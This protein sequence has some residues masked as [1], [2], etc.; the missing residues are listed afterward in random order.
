MPKQGNFIFAG[1]SQSLYRSRA[2]SYFYGTEYDIW[3]DFGPVGSTEKKVGLIMSNFLG[4][5]FQVFM[6]KKNKIVFLKY[7]SAIT[8]KLHNIKM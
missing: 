7:S 2:G 5:V 6:G 1:S 3:A 4:Q 8:K